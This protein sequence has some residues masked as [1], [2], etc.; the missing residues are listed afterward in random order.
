MGV[1][2]DM[3]NRERG[4][5]A[6]P[7][8]PDLVQRARRAARL[9]GSALRLAGDIARGL[10]DLATTRDRRAPPAGRPSTGAT[11][12]APPAPAPQRPVPT[13]KAPPAQGA[14]APP[15]AEPDPEPIRTRTLARLL[16]KQG[17][18]TRAMAMYEALLAEEPDDDALR[19]ELAAVRTEGDGSDEAEMVSVAVDERTVWVSWNVTEGGAERARRLLGEPAPLAVRLAVTAPDPATIVGTRT[20]ELRDVDPSGEWWVRD[21]PEGARATASVGV[22]G[23]GRFV[24]IAHSRAR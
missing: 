23:G 20:R 17:H 13:S 22:L 5:L 15:A 14:D 16:A 2:D 18:H 3:K 24:S 11:T 4:R 10:Y 12:A 1:E 19:R 21:L 6:L 9:G 8:R 7:T